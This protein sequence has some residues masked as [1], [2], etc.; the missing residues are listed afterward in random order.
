MGLLDRFSGRASASALTAAAT[1]IELDDEYESKRIRKGPGA[2]QREAWRFYDTLGECRYPANFVA[3]AIGRINLVPAMRVDPRE[4]PQPLD[5]D[6]D[7]DL[8]IDD[9]EREALNATL[10][11]LAN[12]PQPIQELQRLLAL[13]LFMAGDANLVGYNDVDEGGEVWDVLS[14]DELVL[15]QS[16]GGYARRISME[17]GPGATES[18]PPDAFIVRLYQRHPRFSGWADCAMRAALGYF[19]ELQLLTDAIHASATSRLPAQI[20]MLTRGMLGA[21]PADQTLI[22]QSDEAANSPV[23][24]TLIK[25]F[26]TPVQNPKS[27]SKLVPVI[28]FGE[29][30]DIDAAKLLDPARGIDETAAKQRQELIQRI[31][32]ALDLPPQVLTGIGDLNHWNA[33]Q[34]DEQTFKYHLEPATQLMCQS[35]TQGYFRPHLEQMG[36]T[37]LA[38]FTIWYDASD[39]VSHPNQEA[40]YAEAHQR[41]TVSD[42]AYR[43]AHGI[44]ESDAPDEEERDQRLLEMLYRSMTIQQGQTPPT[45][46]E[47]VAEAEAEPVEEQPQLPPGPPAIEPPAERVPPEP[48][49]APPAQPPPL[50]PVQAAVLP[51]LRA[52]A[53][54]ASLGPL[55]PRFATMER[56]LRLRLSQAADDA[57]RRALERAGNRL[58]SLADR[59]GAQLRAKLAGEDPLMIG[60]LLGPEGVEALGTSPDDLLAGAFAALGVQYATWTRRDQERA[61]A[62]IEEVGDLGEAQ[63][64]A[65]RQQAEQHRGEGW[66]VLVAGLLSLGGRLI[67]DPTTPAPT[68]GEHS[69]FTVPPGL[70]RE[71]LVTAGGGDDGASAGLLSGATM[72]EALGE[73]GLT[74]TS[75]TWLHGDPDVPFWLDK[76]GDAHAHLA[77]DG[78][79]VTA[80]FTADGTSNDPQLAVEPED[81]W[82]GVAFYWPGDHDGCT[83]DIIENIEQASPDEQ[84]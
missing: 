74:V 17:G 47:F 69:D 11:R 82:L 12:G 22:G 34:V 64:I 66:A 41:L 10:D 38:R 52:L 35:L 39:L 40:N 26:E 83:C 32:I 59:G 4:P 71:S 79:D 28:I 30:E 50:P 78:V 31:A 53:A 16:S 19:G 61:L 67:Y 60:S 42:K 81:E 5:P 18:L 24:Q 65:L 84:A 68:R 63:A 75:Y 76:E 7:D 14:V 36:V 77:L 33:W 62:A 23:A 1:I 80:S 37:D 13:N 48:S 70:L 54:S 15:D 27:A 57:M 3:S 72:H 45:F 20:L 58:R 44:P 29:K 6:G 25:H 73:A 46:E 56:N 55:G 2:W 51:P 9:A 43:Q 49:T 8:P 21:G